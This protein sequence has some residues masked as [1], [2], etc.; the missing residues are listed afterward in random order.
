MAARELCVPLTDCINNAI[1]ECK[2]PDI[3][4]LADVGPMF[5]KEHPMLKE[6]NRP[7]RLFPSFSKNL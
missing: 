1:L 5:K 3:L 6:N 2:F 7:I 4:K